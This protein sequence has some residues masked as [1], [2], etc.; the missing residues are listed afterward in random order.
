MAKDNPTEQSHHVS[1]TRRSALLAT[2]AVMVAGLVVMAMGSKSNLCYI[3]A[4]IALV[5]SVGL[6]SLET[7]AKRAQT[8]NLSTCSEP[9]N[10]WPI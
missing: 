7:K 4:G 5:G 3:G 9:T 1:L 2:W 8:E 6:V 10:D